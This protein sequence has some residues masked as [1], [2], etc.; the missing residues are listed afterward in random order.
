MKRVRFAK[1]LAGLVLVFGAAAC[2]DN[3][4]ETTQLTAGNSAVVAAA[5][6][7]HRLGLCDARVS[8]E[9]AGGTLAV[10]I[11]PDF[12]VVQQGP[13]VRVASGTLYAEALGSEPQARS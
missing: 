9:M 7:A 12:R 1:T 10:E 3:G 8:V 2:S 11:D 6:V 13:V 4:P 5:A